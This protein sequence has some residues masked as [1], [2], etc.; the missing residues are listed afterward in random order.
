MKT[1]I[2]EFEEYPDHEIEV[3]LSDIEVDTYFDIAEGLSRLRSNRRAVRALFE[4]FAPFIVRWTFDRPTDADGL[5]K[6][7][8]NLSLAIVNEWVKEVRSAPLPLPRSASDG[9][10]SEAQTE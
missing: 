2:I 6:T 4:R 9:T 1:A 10:P 5:M 8:F 3:Q 7:D